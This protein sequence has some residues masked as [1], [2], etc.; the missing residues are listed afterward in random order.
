MGKAWRQFL[1]YFLPFYFILE[2]SWL[3]ILWQF[4]VDCK[5]TQSYIYLYPFL[6][7]ISGQNILW[8]SWSWSRYSNACQDPVS[9]RQGDKKQ[10]LLWGFWGQHWHWSKRSVPSSQHSRLSMDH[11]GYWS[12]CNQRKWRAMDTAHV[13]GGSMLPAPAEWQL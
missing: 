2:H 11:W 6:E 13:P 7:A 4:Q 10:Y 1:L 3:T 9:I 5:G 12:G 8:A